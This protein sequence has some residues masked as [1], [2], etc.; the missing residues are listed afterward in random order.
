MQ[1]KRINKELLF[2]LTSAAV[3]LGFMAFVTVV[4]PALKMG[5]AE[6]SGINAVFGVEYKFNFLVLFGYLLPLISAICGVVFFNAKSAIFHYVLS[7]LCFLGVI[8]IFLEPVLFRSVNAIENMVEI[9]LHAGPIIGGLL[10][11]ISGIFHI[12]CGYMKR[13]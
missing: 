4:F 9:T 1:K 7:G 3:C 6:V 5:G 12:S 2:V 13:K 11:V 8:L 10:T